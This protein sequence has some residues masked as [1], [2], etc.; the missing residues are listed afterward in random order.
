MS[1]QVIKNIAGLYFVVGAGF[2]GSI[3]DATQ[4]E[5]CDV[6]GIQACAKNMG[7]SPTFVGSAPV[8]K[9]FAVVY[10]RRN[11][12]DANGKI[13]QHEPNAAL[14]QR[15]PSRRRF[16]TLAEAITHG[17]RFAERR[18]NRGDKA[19]TAGHRGFY[20]VETNDP[21]NA[22]VNPVSGLTNSISPR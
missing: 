15:N 3:K 4:V 2:S 22:E 18:A 14:G 13:V 21:V 12:V 7:I 1:K 5:S 20:F 19:G 17:S 8:N 6:A 9:S 10:I 11:D 16:A